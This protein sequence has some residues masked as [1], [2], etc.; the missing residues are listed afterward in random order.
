MKRLLLALVLVLLCAATVFAAEIPPMP[1][2]KHI[3]QFP[4]VF[5]GECEVDKLPMPMMA[6]AV[7]YDEANDM[8]YV[9]LARNGRN[10]TYVIAVDTNGDPVVLWQSTEG[11]T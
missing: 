8:K 6:C 10:I 7:Y 4:V 5:V 11:M 9:V 3:S 1:L 2:R